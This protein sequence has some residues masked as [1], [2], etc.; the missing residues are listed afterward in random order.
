[1]KLLASLG[2]FLGAVLLLLVGCGQV[3]KAAKTNHLNQWMQADGKLKVLCTTAMIADLVQEVGGDL[4]DCLVLIQGESDPHSYQL[5]KGDEEKFSRADVIFYNGLGLEHGPSVASLLQGS[6]KAFSVGEYLRREHR[7]SIVVLHNAIDPHVWM[8]VSLWKEC[9]PFIV[10]VLSKSLPQRKELL[11]GHGAKLMER[12]SQ[13]HAEIIG[14]IGSL[15]LQSRYLVTSHEAFNYFARAYLCPKDEL[16]SD[17]WQERAMAP[18]GLAP[19]SQLSTAD[20]QRLVDHIIEYKIATIFSEAN[21]SQDSL[22]KMVDACSK[23]GFQTSIALKSL[24]ADSMGKD[25][26]YSDMMRYDSQ[27]IEEGLSKNG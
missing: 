4:V 5:V 25:A 22:K 16:S 12:L 27:V 6:S 2:L 13:L 10:E 3:S 24:Y 1:M 11:Q 17:K 21:V 14:R 19:D 9:V 7:E 26:T 15:P 20:I 18:E 23:K 8:D